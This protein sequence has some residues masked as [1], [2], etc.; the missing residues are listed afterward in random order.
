MLLRWGSG[1]KSIKDF[2]FLPAELL[3][4]ASLQK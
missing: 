4:D 1:K 3:K 2:E